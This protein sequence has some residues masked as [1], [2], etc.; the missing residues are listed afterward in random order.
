MPLEAVRG[1]YASLP[2]HARVL[3]GVNSFKSAIST[4]EKPLPFRG[5]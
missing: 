2:F 5:N 3:E 4:L 1:G